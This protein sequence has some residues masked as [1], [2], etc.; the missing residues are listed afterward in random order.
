MPLL[1]SSGTRG[2]GRRIEEGT[3]GPVVQL[4]TVPEVGR[5]ARRRRTVSHYFVHGGWFETDGQLIDNAHK[6]AHIPTTIV[7]GVR[8][9]TSRGRVRVRR[10]R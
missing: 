9:P 4:T 7:Q 6:I 5:V 2:R 8:I 10:A 3:L 1:A